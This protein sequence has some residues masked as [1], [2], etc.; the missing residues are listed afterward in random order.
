MRMLALLA[1]PSALLCSAPSD[2]AKTRLLYRL[3][4]A[5]DFRRL[6]KMPSPLATGPAREPYAQD[7]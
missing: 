3:A 7:T 2:G 1:S 6:G 4:R 5:A